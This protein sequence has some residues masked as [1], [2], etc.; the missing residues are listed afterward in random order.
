MK[1]SRNSIPE[2]DVVDLSFLM[3]YVCTGG[4]SLCTGNY[5]IY[6]LFSLPEEGFLLT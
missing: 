3:L 6:K 5:V 1:C 4:M 2:E